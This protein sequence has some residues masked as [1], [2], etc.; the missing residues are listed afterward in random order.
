MRP[1]PATLTASADLWVTFVACVAH[2][3]IRRPMHYRDADP[4]SRPNQVV[5]HR[6]IALP[7]VIVISLML[8]LGVVGAMAAALSLLRTGRLECVRG[9]AHQCVIVRR[10]GPFTT[11]DA[12]PLD[13]IRGVETRR[14]QSKGTPAHS[15]G[16]RLEADWIQ[17]CQP[18]SFARA[19]LTR[20]V[21]ADFVEGHAVSPSTI[22]LDEPS[23]SGAL[24]LLVGLVLAALPF[25]FLRS[26][27]LE[28]DFGNGRIEYTRFRFPL[29]AV[30]QTLHAA[31]V[32]R[33]RV[34]EG[35][36]RKRTIVYT[37]VLDLHVK[38]ELPLVDQHDGSR[39]RHEA[40]ATRINALLEAIHERYPAR[41]AR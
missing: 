30:R 11:H 27:R 15:V 14:H 29:P 35:R 1:L 26:A 25:V 38:G 20:T 23:P 22:P 28:F 40:A 36:G 12:I 31:D 32:L 33:A 16:F 9:G 41:A 3:T 17:L 7:L 5:H 4:H 10:Y 13:R 39:A 24:F 6:P 21:I 37:V 8:A 2:A 18:T 34:R 19:E